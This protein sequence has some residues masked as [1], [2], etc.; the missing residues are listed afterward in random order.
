MRPKKLI[1]D[2][3]SKLR[4]E[5][6][7]DLNSNILNT[8][9][10]NQSS[11]GNSYLET[12]E[13]LVF[14]WNSPIN[15]QIVADKIETSK[16]EIDLANKILKGDDGSSKYG[17]VLFDDFGV[18]V[19]NMNQQREWFMKH[20][21]FVFSIGMIYDNDD[22]ELMR[23]IMELFDNKHDRTAFL[24]NHFKVFIYNDPFIQQ[25]EKELIIANGN[26]HILLVPIVN[27]SD[28]EIALAPDKMFTAN[29]P[30][31]K[32]ISWNEIINFMT[33]MVSRYGVICEIVSNQH[34]EQ[35][36][37]Y[38]RPK[39]NYRDNANGVRPSD[40]SITLEMKLDPEVYRKIDTEQ[41]FLET[42][43]NNFKRRLHVDKVMKDRTV[44]RSRSKGK[45]S[46]LTRIAQ[47][48]PI[49][50]SHPNKNAKKG[51]VAKIQMAKIQPDNKE[52]EY[53][54]YAVYDGLD[55]NM[56]PIGS[57]PGARTDFSM[58]DT[59]EARTSVQLPGGF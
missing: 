32:F 53:Q 39:S 51:I 48:K 31:S 33:S 47:N 21:F 20:V 43:D 40:M 38:N 52:H 24:M 29:G 41:E 17:K 57:A 9:T 54:K 58:M 26:Y 50:T 19:L 22:I 49:E 46:L 16:R 12:P 11:I 37:R 2:Q 55:A 8:N 44:D 6:F 14:Q 7:H 23:D 18:R 30:I 36:N 4:N 27:A 42:R 10:Q 34:E 56:M 15:N 13:S 25:L 45:N 5:A 59:I 1:G 28:S 3:N 35:K